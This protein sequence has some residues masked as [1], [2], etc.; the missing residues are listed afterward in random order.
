MSSKSIKTEII[1]KYKKKDFLKR[2]IQ[3]LIGVFIVSIAYNVFV[4]PN[5]LVPKGVGGIAVIL[6]TT[7]GWNNSAIIFILNGILLIASLLFLGIDKTKATI[8]GSLIFPIFV[9]LTEDINVWLQID[10]SQVLLSAV[11]GGIIYG[12][13]TG[14]IFRA[15][16]TT[17]GTDIINQIVSKYGKVTIGKSMLVSDGLIVIA[18]GVFL[19][20]NN[21]MYSI[22]S[23]YITSLISDRV[24]LGISDSKSFLI[25][26]EK[27]EEVKDYIMNT[28]KHGVTVYEAKGGYKTEKEKVLMTVLP[29]KEYYRLKEGIQK[30]DKDVFYIITDTYEVFGVE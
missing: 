12:I 14:L 28:L 27:E 8:F 25:I 1:E 6:N 7:L 9:K 21:M 24:I 2:V 4:A 23:L 11:F 17:G 10:S 18:S 13:G 15:G 26:T 3:L 5:G 16:F 29:T 19:G 30:I 20:I 22:L